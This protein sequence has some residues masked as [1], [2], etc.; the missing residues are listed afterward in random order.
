ME[1]ESQAFI[2]ASPAFAGFDLE[3][4]NLKKNLSGWIGD[5]VRAPRISAGLNQLCQEL[6]R[7]ISRGTISLPARFRVARL[8]SYARRLVYEDPESGVCVLAM[9]WAPGQA[10]PLHDHSGLWGVEAVLAGE[11]ENVPFN[12]IAQHNGQ[13]QFQAGAVERV[14]AGST[15][16]L[17]PPFEHHVT[18]NV[19]QTVAI[20]LNIYGGHMP[21]CNIFLPTESGAY[22]RQR[23]A[24]SYS[25]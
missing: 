6:E 8:D 11:I 12:M 3:F 20:T 15:S 9:I 2:T 24:L 22:V 23:R 17:L 14:V 5:A 16:Y 13:Y 1:Q 18:R 19:S 10:T 4:E 21:A 7:A 25:D